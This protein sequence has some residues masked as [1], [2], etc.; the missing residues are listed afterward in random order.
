MNS[1][2]VMSKK[3]TYIRLEN[4]FHHSSSYSFFL[5][6]W[7]IIFMCLWFV[8]PFVNFKLGIAPFLLLAGFW[9]ITTDV[10]WIFERLS[11]DLLMFF[12]WIFTLSPYILT[13]SFRYGEMNPRNVLISFF[14][15]FGGLF[16]NHYYMYYKKNAVALGRIALFAVLFYFFASFQSFLGLKQFPLAA[17]ALATGTDP[18]QATYLSLGIGGFGFVYSGVFMIIILL[19]FVLKL[20]QG[21]KVFYRYFSSAVIIMLTLMLVSA[22]YATSLLLVFMGVLFVLFIRGKKSLIF[23][24]FLAILFII[25]LPKDLIGRFF[26]DVAH[27][28]GAND[29]IRSKFI[30]LAQMFIH[31]AAGAQTS[32]RGQLY[33]SSLQTFLENPLFGVYGPFGN[34]TQYTIGGHSGWLDF[35]AYYGIFGSIPLFATIILNFKKQWNFFG[36]HRYQRFLLTAQILFILLGSI[37]PVIYIYQIGFVL[38]IV[39]PALPFM[40]YAFSK[41]GGNPS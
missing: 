15:F 8:S 25:I 27:L 18:L 36:N 6:N 17:R 31:D 39:A 16:I 2:T 29:V 1:V 19:Y 4:R 9:L 30:D 28:F 14:L 11:F 12:V 21:V 33:M 40:P 35:L 23:Y 32:V 41:K 5:N 7:I 34:D 10:R 26:L 37:N 24:F 3:N 13:G 20:N 38:F 22:S